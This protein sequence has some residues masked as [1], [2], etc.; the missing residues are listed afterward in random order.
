VEWND[1][2]H[3]G[4]G[5]ERFLANAVFGPDHPND[6]ARGTAVDLRVEAELAHPRHDAV[7]LV[8]GGVGLSDDDHGAVSRN[9]IMSPGNGNASREPGIS[10]EGA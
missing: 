7:D 5:G 3:A 4:H 8:F 1:S 2:F 6:D 10:R 9:T